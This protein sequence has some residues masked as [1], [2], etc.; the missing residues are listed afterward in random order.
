M[1]GIFTI[2]EDRPRGYYSRLDVY[3]DGARGLKYFEGTAADAADA[4]T[5]PGV[6][7]N[8]DAYDAGHPLLLCRARV[9]ERIGGPWWIVR[10]EYA[11]ASLGGVA[12][13]PGQQEPGDSWTEEV[14]SVGHVRIRADIN[15]DPIPETTKLVPTSE[16][17]V[18]AYRA[19]DDTSD[20]YD[21]IKGKVNA[22]TVQL[23]P[24]RFGAGTRT[25]A[26]GTLLAMPREV[27][28]IRLGLVEITY[29]FGY[30]PPPL[31]WKDVSTLDDEN[32]EPFLTLIS[33]I[34]EPATFPA[35]GLWG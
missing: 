5:A 20:L 13:D 22:N 19:T 30:A 18:R 6:P 21:S 12:N 34:Y 1:A 26:P 10:C 28:G 7:N 3:S 14:P 17:R 32:G 8:G 2:Q 11:D 24:Q 29:V 31:G 4:L 35:S 16:Y 25:A 15:L 33:D 23:P 27:R 9:P